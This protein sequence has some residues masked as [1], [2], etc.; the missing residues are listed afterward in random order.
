MEYKQNTQSDFHSVLMA[1]ILASLDN[2]ILFSIYHIL[3]LIGSV[4]ILRHV[5]TQ[6]KGTYGLD[7]YMKAFYIFHYSFYDLHYCCG[8]LKTHF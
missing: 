8:V 4:V 3:F 5:H 7:V 2:N 1:L 6:C